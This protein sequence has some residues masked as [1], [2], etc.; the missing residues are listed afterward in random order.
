MPNNR[1]QSV[2]W[3]ICIVAWI[4][5]CA[6]SNDTVIMAAAVTFVLGRRLL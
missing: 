2:A 6:I 1:S 4:H 3:L 5:T